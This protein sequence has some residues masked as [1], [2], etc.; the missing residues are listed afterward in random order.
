MHYQ[1]AK[2][3]LKSLICIDY[4]TLKVSILALLLVLAVYGPS[5]FSII[6]EIF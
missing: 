6:E 3:R 1:W 2:K 4:S 5:I